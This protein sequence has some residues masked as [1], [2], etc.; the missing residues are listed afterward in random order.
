V[1]E[2]LPQAAKGASFARAR[3]SDI[4]RS[5]D[6]EVGAAIPIGAQDATGLFR[7][8]RRNRA[9]GALPF[10]AC[11]GGP[12]ARKIRSYSRIQAARL[13][14][15]AAD[16]KGLER[17]Q[18]ARTNW[19]LDDNRKTLTLAFPKKPIAVKLTR[20]EL[21]KCS[22]TLESFERTWNLALPPD[23]APGQMVK[24]ISSPVRRS[25][26]DA[27]WGTPCSMQTSSPRS[28]RLRSTGHTIYHL[29]R[30]C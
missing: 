16:R 27:I 4:E 6:R 20:M 2:E 24:A 19:R 3:G 8:D 13:S 30:R 7:V 25:E 14:R 17:G 10:A 5:G 21:M 11:R 22:E 9:G 12:L 23:Y 1:S 28:S 18:D 26:P 15:G 29:R